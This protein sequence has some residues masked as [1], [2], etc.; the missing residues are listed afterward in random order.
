MREA[1]PVSPELLFSMLFSHGPQLHN[2][3]SLGLPPLE[4]PVLHM[5][6]FVLMEPI[7]GPSALQVQALFL[8]GD[9]E[10]N[11]LMFSIEKLTYMKWQSSKHVRCSELCFPFPLSSHSDPEDFHYEN[12]YEKIWAPMTVFTAWAFSPTLRLF[13]INSVLTHSVDAACSELSSEPFLLLSNRILFSSLHILHWLWHVS[14]V[15][16]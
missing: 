6:S 16:K 11:S 3:L 2:S 7:P 10:E 4:L 1:R 9:C 14:A 8:F 15:T 13:K 5:S 12:I